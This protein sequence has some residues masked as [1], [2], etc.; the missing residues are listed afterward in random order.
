[1]KDRKLETT[2]SFDNSCTK[3]DNPHFG[4]EGIYIRRS[5]TAVQL[6]NI[7][8]RRQQHRRMW[9]VTEQCKRK[10]CTS[11]HRVRVR[12]IREKKNSRFLIK[13]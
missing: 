10:L 3:N 13:F 2:V 7:G 9:E 11:K 4:S 1:M 12:V 6:P 8:E 5:S